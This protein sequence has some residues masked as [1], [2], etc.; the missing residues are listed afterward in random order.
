[1]NRELHANIAYVVYTPS[2]L[3]VMSTSYMTV[4]ITVNYKGIRL[5]ISE[6]M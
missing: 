1:M 4:T 2:D 6:L 5:L 3:Y